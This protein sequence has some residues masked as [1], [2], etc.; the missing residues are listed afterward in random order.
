MMIKFWNNRYK[1]FLGILA[2]CFSFESIVGELPST[3]K[4]NK[5][6]LN[7]EVVKIVFAPKR[8]TILSAEVSAQVI[9]IPKDLGQAVFNGEIVVILDNV[10]YQAN[11][12]KAKSDLERNT[13][14]YDAINKLFEKK[15]ESM[16][17]LVEAKSEFIN[18]KAEK[19]FANKKLMDTSIRSPFDGKI[20]NVLIKEYEF[21]ERGRPL[22]EIINDEQLIGKMLLPAKLRGSIGIDQ[23]IDIF[24]TLMNETVQGTIT[25]I[26]PMIDPT[27]ATLK[28]EIE[29]DNSDQK[30]VPGMLGLTFWE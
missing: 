11:F 22:I 16:I 29:I 6:F 10:E 21:A 18:A 13:K 7:K 1:M 5:Q 30:I 23:E 12:I 14:R 28:V 2:L 26:A 25:H 8:E 24:I 17:R 19:L 3:Q 27:S 9:E 20:A 15:E 4:I